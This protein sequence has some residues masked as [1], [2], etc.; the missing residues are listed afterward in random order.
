MRRLR[1]L[2]LLSLLRALLHLPGGVTPPAALA[3]AAVQSPTE[4]TVLAAASA[5]WS[6]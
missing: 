3:V 1:P 4:M 5:G 2:A 6:A